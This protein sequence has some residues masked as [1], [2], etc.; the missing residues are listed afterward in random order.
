ML[1]IDDPYLQELR[2]RLAVEGWGKEE[3]G[4]RVAACAAYGF[5]YCHER[6]RDVT[7]SLATCL[8]NSGQVLLLPV[9]TS[10]PNAAIN[11]H[12]VKI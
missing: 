8:P 9:A 7:A 1:A 6:M 3:E 4:K 10:A 5:S 2:E 12:T 11:Q